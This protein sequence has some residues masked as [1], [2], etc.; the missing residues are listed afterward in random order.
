[1]LGAASLRGR[2][3]VGSDVFTYSYIHPRSPEHRV[4]LVNFG[5]M[6]RADHIDELRA[7]LRAAHDHAKRTR[8]DRDELIWAAYRESEMSMRQIAARFDDLSHQRVAQI[9]AEN[10][11][12]T[13][14]PPLNEPNDLTNSQSAFKRA[15]TDLDKLIREAYRSGMTMAEIARLVDLT[16]RRISQIIGRTRPRSVPLNIT[17]KSPARPLARPAGTTRRNEASACSTRLPRRARQALP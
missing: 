6:G 8:T 17:D 16:D 15:K 7:A 14:G 5:A 10:Q 12:L 11:H 13:F 9:I 2:P 4:R 1:V 3:G